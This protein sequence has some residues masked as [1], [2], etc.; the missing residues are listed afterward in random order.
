MF[1]VFGIEFSRMCEISN[2]LRK[3]SVKYPIKRLQKLFD[4]IILFLEDTQIMSSNSLEEKLLDPKNLT[5]SLLPVHRKTVGNRQAL[6]IIFYAALPYAISFLIS[7]A[8]RLSAYIFLKGYDDVT[9]VGAFG[10]GMTF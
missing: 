6:K 10:I 8:V 3:S 2:Y 9:I 7:N 4:I 1:D 5:H